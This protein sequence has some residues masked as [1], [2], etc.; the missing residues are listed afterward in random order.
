MTHVAVARFETPDFADRTAPDWLKQIYDEC[1]PMWGPHPTPGAQSLLPIYEDV[2]RLLGRPLRRWQKLAALIGTEL[3]DDGRPRWRHFFVTLPRQG[4]KSWLEFV[5]FVVDMIMLPPATHV[6]FVSQS[7]S[8]GV[9]AVFQKWVPKVEHT[10]LWH[11]MQFSQSRDKAN[12]FLRSDLTRVTV[13]LHT[14]SE[15]SGH[16]H[17]LHRVHADEIWS[18]PPR[19]FED[20]VRQAVRAVLN[21]QVMYYSTVG[22]PDQP[23]DLLDGMILG[24]RA[25][26]S[27]GWADVRRAGLEWSGPKELDVGDEKGWRAATPF[28]DEISDDGEGVTIDSLREDF[29][30]DT[31]EG[32]VVWRRAGLNQIGEQTTLTA[33]SVHAYDAL[34]ADPATAPPPVPPVVYGIDAP[35]EGGFTSIAAADAAGWVAVVAHERGA[36]WVVDRLIAARD[37]GATQRPLV[38]MSAAG[39]L[40]AVAAELDIAGFEVRRLSSSEMSAA[41]ISFRDRVHGDSGADEAPPLL[42][43]VADNALRT[44]VLSARPSNPG[45][46]FAFVRTAAD[47]NIAPMYAVA[48][49][50]AGAAELAVRPTKSVVMRRV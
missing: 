6:M 36:H 40:A 25:A 43:I 5:G 46:P 30:D 3:L 31:T 42:H 7:G 48:A 26:A 35:P 20:S 11:M 24:N 13:D 33:V 12:P 49:A 15:K 16:G 8:A 34:A 17:T 39:P 27:A 23:S 44:A 10:A 18:F 1:P 29:D 37:R 28:L 21:A 14:G 22:S 2:A 19:L 4:G 32:K 45:R 47:Q 50:L 41:C 38:V 9:A